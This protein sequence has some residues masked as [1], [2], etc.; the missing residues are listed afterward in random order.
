MANRN[1][2]NGGKLYS[3]NVMPVQI[4]GSIL[5]GTTGAVT[6][7]SG[8]GISSVTRLAQGQ[9]QVIL[10][11]NYNSLLNFQAHMRS[12]ISGTPVAGGSLSVGSVYQI[13]TLGSTTTAQWHAAG[14]PAQVVPAIGVIFKAATVGAGSG[15]SETLITSGISSI[16]AMGIQSTMIA[17]D[18]SIQAGSIL[19]FQTMAATSSSVTTQIASNP[20]SGSTIAFSIILNNSSVKTP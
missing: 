19:N 5:I 1:F 2:P 20:A 7:F 16:E 8:S 12:P 13:V 11:D 18:P 10:K 14:V 4:N 15:T 9:Y 17:P 6:S 3:F